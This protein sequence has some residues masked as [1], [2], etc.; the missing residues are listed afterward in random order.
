MAFLGGS[1]QDPII[2]LRLACLQISCQDLFVRKGGLESL[3]DLF[4]GAPFSV[5]FLL[6][7]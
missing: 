6:A 1:H 7:H 5:P 2:A 3:A 4:R